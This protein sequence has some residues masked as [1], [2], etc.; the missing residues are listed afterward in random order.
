MCAFVSFQLLRECLNEG[1]EFAVHL[2]VDIHGEGEELATV[3]SRETIILVVF[4]NSMRLKILGDR[5]MMCLS[6]CLS[7]C[8]RA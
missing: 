3:C 4:S 7:V 8:D 1:V 2:S 6:V 5:L